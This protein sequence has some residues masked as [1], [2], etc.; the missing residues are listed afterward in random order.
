MR[1]LVFGLWL[2]PAIDKSSLAPALKRRDW[3]AFARGYNGQAYKRHGYHTK[4]AAAYARYA[5]ST[6]NSQLEPTAAGNIRPSVAIPGKAPTP[7]RTGIAAWM[8]LIGT[9]VGLVGSVLRR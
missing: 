5:E 2:E 7:N 9:I 8:R 6:E 4:I 1:S 3:E